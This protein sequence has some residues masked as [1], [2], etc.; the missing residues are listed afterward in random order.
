M[1]THWSI[2]RGESRGT[3]LFE[4]WTNIQDF[5]TEIS[6]ECGLA[7]TDVAIG[8]RTMTYPLANEIHIANAKANTLKSLL[9]IRLWH[10]AEYL[11]IVPVL[12]V[13]SLLI[14]IVA[15]TAKIADFVEVLAT[16][17][18]FKKPDLGMNQTTNVEEPKHVNVEE[19]QPRSAEVEESMD[20]TENVEE[21]RMSERDEIKEGMEEGDRE[22]DRGEQLSS[23]TEHAP[24]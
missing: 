10:N 9:K 20:E 5:C 1:R 4:L 16:K 6:S 24:T 15:C 7:L 17:A 2:S 14:D 18:K 12:T 22:E 8:L 11:D 19:E 3:T 13:A 21:S 23:K